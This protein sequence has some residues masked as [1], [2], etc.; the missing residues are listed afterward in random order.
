MADSFQY[1]MV[2]A[3]VGHFLSRLR[4]LLPGF[5]RIA[6]T[7]YSYS[8]FAPGDFLAYNDQR[9]RTETKEICGV[10]VSRTYRAYPT[11]ALG[12]AQEIEERAAF[13]GAPYGHVSNPRT[14]KTYYAATAALP[15]PG[16]LA[17]VVYPGGKTETCG[18]EYGRARGVISGSMSG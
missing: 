17:T 4:R 10:E 12:Q 9:P 5:G 3:R 15:L 18:Y 7:R 16:R 13:P 1:G 11:N 2:S 8:L 6:M 14:V